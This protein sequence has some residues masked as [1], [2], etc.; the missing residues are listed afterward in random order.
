MA[1]D[2]RIVPG[3]KLVMR[4]ADDDPAGAINDIKRFLDTPTG[5]GATLPTRGNYPGEHFFNTETQVEW[6][7]NGDSWI[8]SDQAASGSSLP[9][10]GQ[11]VGQRW[12]DSSFQR[13]WLWDGTTWQI[14]YEPVQ[15][16]N[17][18]VSQAGGF[19]IPAWTNQFAWY[20][21]SNGNCT[22]WIN[23]VMTTSTT[24]SGNPVLV[25]LP[26]AAKS[27]SAGSV[28]IGFGLVYHNSTRYNVQC[29]QY[30]STHVWFGVDGAGFIGSNPAFNLFITDEI[31]FNLTYPIA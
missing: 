15:S 22:V 16:Y 17:P 23:V 10:S 27:P 20:R 6:C 12:F 21:R 5:F 9:S 3:Q 7:W 31:R 24:G 4:N 30:D 29:E 13:E 8:V 19:N 26:V 11:Y 14:T 1:G 2:V 25:T 28:N 18:V